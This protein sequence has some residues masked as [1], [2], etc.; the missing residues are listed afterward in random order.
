M[1]GIRRNGLKG[2]SRSGKTLG[3]TE[4]EAFDF[5]LATKRKLGA[6]RKE[7]VFAHSEALRYQF[8]RMRDQIS[9]DALREAKTEEQVNAALLGIDQYTRGH[10]PGASAILATIHDPKYPKIRPISFLAESCALS[11]QT[12]PK[13]SDRYSPRYSR[14][15]C[16]EERKRRGPPPKPMTDVEYW[17]LQAESGQKVPVRYV[18]RI[19]RLQAKKRGQSGAHKIRTHVTYVDIPEIIEPVTKKRTTVWLPD[20]TVEKLKRLSAATGAP[21]AELFRRAVEA[22]LKTS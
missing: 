22:Y 13:G 15:I 6:R 12:N 11:L 19:N 2:M 18:R 3:T 16:Y 17:A 5:P 1:D 9:W 7:L 20:T 10:L 4:A 8:Q 21:M 14:D